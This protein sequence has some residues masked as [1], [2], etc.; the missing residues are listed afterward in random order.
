MGNRLLGQV[1]PYASGVKIVTLPGLAEK[2]DVSDFLA[3]HSAADLV[4]EIKKAPQ[5]KPAQSGKRMLVD[6]SD[7]MAACSGANRLAH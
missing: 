1:A 5:W 3:S 4:A 6:A 7:F 2:G